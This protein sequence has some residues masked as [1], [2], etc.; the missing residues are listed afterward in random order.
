MREVA[1]MDQKQFFRKKTAEEIM[2]GKELIRTYTASNLAEQ[3]GMLTDDEVLVVA[4]NIIPA[5]YYPGG[6]MHERRFASV[7]FLKHGTEVKPRRDYTLEEI[8]RNRKLPFQQRREAF[9]ALARYDSAQ[10]YSGYTF[11]P[12]AR[13]GDARARKISLLQCV[14]GAKLFNY[15]GNAAGGINVKNYGTLERAARVEK[16]G[17]RFEVKVPS[18]RRKKPRYKVEMSSVAT[19]DSPNKYAIANSIN[20]THTC[21][22]LN[23]KNMRYKFAAGKESSDIKNV[24]AHEISAYLAVIE[25]MKNADFN[26]VPL[27]MSWIAI[28]TQY[29]VDCLSKA[30]NHAV[31]EYRSTGGNICYAPLNQG[32]QEIFLWSLTHKE[33]KA[34]KNPHE[35][36]DRCWFAKEKIASYKF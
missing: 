21:D 31:A 5:K 10:F 35:G 11:R 20:S 3:I 15:A 32:E 22:Y 17:S 9:E 2:K 13:T 7:K 16:E 27:Q 36:H 23:Y 26:L 34:E 29:T 4:T 12:A 25:N 1:K 28:P 6:K 33:I 8:M 24:C 18:R 19:I 30:R 14:E